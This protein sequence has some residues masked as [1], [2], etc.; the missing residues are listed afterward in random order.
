MS[1]FYQYHLNDENSLALAGHFA[2]KGL[3]SE[4]L[5]SGKA[6]L[7]MPF[8]VFGGDG[9]KHHWTYFLVK[10]AKEIMEEEANMAERKIHYVH[11][12]YHEDYEDRGAVYYFSFCCQLLEYGHADEVFW[13]A[14]GLVGRKEEFRRTRREIE[15]GKFT[16]DSKGPPE[17]SLVYISI[18]VDFFPREKINHQFPHHGPEVEVEEVAERIRKIGEESVVFG[19]DVTGY[20][21]FR[22]DNPAKKINREARKVSMGNIGKL[23]NALEFSLKRGSPKLKKIMR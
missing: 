1:E 6:N 3:E 11:I 23:R 13:M 4:V 16:E 2:E 8:I 7:K 12:D 22:R 20:S 5:Q 9:N 19:S 10:K 18:D 14:P 21:E 17:N 15:F